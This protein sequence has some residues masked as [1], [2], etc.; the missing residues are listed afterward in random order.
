[1]KKIF[2]LVNKYLYQHFISICILFVAIILSS[3]CT[4]IIPI[5]SGNFV[6]YLVDE[7]KQQGIIFFCLLFAIVS[8]AN[9]LIGFLS[10]RIYTKVNLQILYEMG[11]SYIQHMQKMNVLYFSNKNISQITQQISVDIKSVVDFFFDFF[12]NASI[13]F[14]KILIPALLVFRISR[15]MCFLMLLLMLIYLISYIF[16]KQKLYATSYETKKI[17]MYILEIC[18]NNCLK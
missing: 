15:G 12:S 9:I 5:I 18:M 10:N 4:L 14:F 17:K 16:F 3:I 2:R 13:N 1:M 7:K 8:I 11:Q 6:D